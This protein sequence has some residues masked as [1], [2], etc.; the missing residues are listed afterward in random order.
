MDSLIS[1]HR[2][3]AILP[4]VYLFDKSKLPEGINVD[5]LKKMEIDEGY[6]VQR[7][8][9]ERVL[10]KKPKYTV[11]IQDI[12]ETNA[13]L[14]DAGV[15]YYALETIDYRELQHVLDVD[16]VL[17]GRVENDFD[18]KTGYTYTGSGIHGGG[19]ATT[20]VGTKMTVNIDLYDTRNAKLLWKMKATKF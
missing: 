3:V 5:F 9:Y 18:R 17:C 11:E 20:M 10:I 6:R 1:A 4:C 13:R 19:I 2:K 15:D 12:H 7:D 16:A 14:A 8:I